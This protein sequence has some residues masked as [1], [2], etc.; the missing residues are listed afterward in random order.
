MRRHDLAWLRPGAAVGFLCGIAD[1]ALSA[2]VAEW[3]AAGR[4]LVVAR[5]PAGAAGVLLG[6]TLPASEGR[7]RVGCLADPRDLLRTAPPLA[8]GACL[9]RLPDSVAAPLARLERRLLAGGL[10][11]GVYGSLAWEAASGETYRHAG[12]DV[13]LICD[14]ASRD[15]FALAIA[16]LS[17][18]AAGLP[19][20]LDGEIR[21]PDGCAVAWKELAAAGG[22]AAAQ[23]L[24]KGAA[25]V[26]L[27]P[28]GS[29]LV[30]F[31]EEHC[32]A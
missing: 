3:I 23:V 8:I 4:P 26:A 14:A 24:V 17:E 28:V 5:Q 31:D 20:G 2:R 21:F 18:A 32:H 1:A 22:D 13:D 12:S 25:E 10:R 16:A 19:C 30:Q 27:L 15:Q 11:V 6:L 7:R 29:L 9:A